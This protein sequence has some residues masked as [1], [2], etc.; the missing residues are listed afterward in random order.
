MPK[1]APFS[2][3]LPK[4][5]TLPSLA[6]FD[7]GRAPKEPKAPKAPKPDYPDGPLGE[8]QITKAAKAGGDTGQKEPNDPGWFM[9][10]VEKLTDTLDMP[11]NAI[12][13]VAFGHLFNDDE[14][15]A[16]RKNWAGHTVLDGSDVAEKIGISREDHP[17]ANAAAGLAVDIVADPLTYLG[18]G[19]G[20]T[21]GKMAG[22]AGLGVGPRVLKS[23]VKTVDKIAEGIAGYRA[24]EHGTDVGKHI[25]KHLADQGL[26]HT[27][28]P[29]SLKALAEN[30]PK[31]L[32]AGGTKAAEKLAK[33]EVAAGIGRSLV[34]KSEEA[35]RKEALDFFVRHGQRG[36]G[37]FHVPFTNV[38][39]SIPGFGSQAKRW[40]MLNELN[41]AIESG[42]K[43]GIALGGQRITK[44]AK[45]TMM[46]TE[47]ITPVTD[48]IAKGMGKAQDAE[49]GG[50]L[51]AA[52]KV[53]SG[54]RGLGPACRSSAGRS[55]RKK[56]WPNCP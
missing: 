51:G 38:G 40:G 16:M 50:L 26:E 39:L 15:G 55:G 37:L 14:K 47:Q 5:P 29:V 7:S 12:R 4:L 35:G 48:L 24:A 31:S 1:S 28:D 9:G 56:S 21:I 30:L 8:E 27:M 25:L 44:L 43:A 33:R 45:E 46:G 42:D 13:H 10:G 6:S 49:R 36:M 34:S 22:K 3:S 54:I 19:P 20:R 2:L 17:W 23:G 32:A 18:A 41:M 52:T 53:E 11:G